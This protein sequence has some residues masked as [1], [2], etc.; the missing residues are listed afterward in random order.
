MRAHLTHVG[1]AT[2]LV[3]LPGLT[4]LTDPVLGGPCDCHFGFGMRSRHVRGPYVARAA[5]PPIDVA[6]V[7][8]DQHED[9]LDAEGRAV[10]SSAGAV[11]TTRAA[12]RRLGSAVGLG[13][14]E[15]HVLRT[16]GLELTITAT[17]ARHGPPLSLPFV[18]PVIGFVLE[19]P[20]QSRGALYV[21]GDTVWFGGIGEIA[22]RK[23]VG[24]AILHLGR[25]GYLG[26]AFTMD[27]AAGARAAEELGAH[28]IVPV[29]YDDWTHFTE[30]QTNIEPAFAA[31]GLADRLVRLEKGRRTELEL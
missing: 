21:S 20:G 11:I 13:D 9:N 18:G 10:L 17:P 3:E 7:S 23:R 1:T 28:T 29:H 2:V 27:A 30:P 24:T 8:H 31:R 14:F 12:A 26:A 22:R 19:W 4:I 5:L 25:A 6:L 15:T 16:A